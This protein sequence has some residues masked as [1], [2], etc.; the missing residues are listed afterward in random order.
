[1]KGSLPKPLR[2]LSKLKALIV[3]HNELTMLNNLAR[4]VEL[5]TLVVSHN[6]LRSL[7]DSA[8]SLQK[9]SKISAASNDLSD[10][11]LPD[12]STLGNLRE[13]KLNNNPRLSSLPEHFARWGK[14]ALDEGGSKMGRGLEVVDFSKCGFSAWTA[15]RPLAAH[16]SVVNLGLRDNLVV[17]S[18]KEEGFEDYK[19]KIMVL[20]PKLRVLDSRRFDS[21]FFDLKRRRSEDAVPTAPASKKRSRSAVDKDDEGDDESSASKRRTRSASA[22][23]AASSMGNDTNVTTTSEGPATS[24]KASRK[25]GK[26]RSQRAHRD[27]VAREVLATLRGDEGVKARATNPE[28]ETAHET[29]KGDDDRPPTFEVVDVSSSKPKKARADK[30]APAPAVDFAS[31]F[32]GPSSAAGI[33]AGGASSGW[34]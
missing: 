24:D 7:P 28:P 4:L 6:K 5:N 17:E 23:D 11:G 1:M 26:R 31:L 32:E 10:V 12:L 14:A 34:D 27:A 9:L 3:P 8:S 30:D 20:M 16:S 22:S 33:G 25:R 21:K 15:L 2:C 13:V 19:N 18:I 29:S